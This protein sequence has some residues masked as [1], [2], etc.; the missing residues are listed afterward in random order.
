MCGIAG[1]FLINPKKNSPEQKLAIFT[2]FTKLF[3]ETQSRG[4]DASGF[5]YIDE[6]RHNELITVKG[7]ITSKN[8]VKEKKF[9][10]LKNELPQAL[11]AHCR[12]A[13]QGSPVENFNNHPITVDKK[14]AL[15]HNG[16]I[17]N[18]ASL[19]IDYDLKSKSKGQVDSEIIP[20]LIQLRI[21]QLMQ[22][23]ADA[24]NSQEDLD[25]IS[26]AKAINMTSQEL[27]GGFACAMINKD[28]PNTL[29][30]FNHNNPINLA[31]CE[32]LQCI[33]FASEKDHLE[34][35]FGEFKEEVTK[36]KIWKQNRYK[37]IPL[38]EK[39][40]DDTIIVIKLKD[41]KSKSKEV[42][43]VIP[44][45]TAENLTSEVDGVT[46]II[47]PEVEKDEELKITCYEMDTRSYTIDKTERTIW[48]QKD[49]KDIPNPK[50][51]P[52]WAFEKLTKTL[53]LKDGFKKVYTASAATSTT[54]HSSLVNGRNGRGEITTYGPNGSVEHQY[55]RGCG[56]GYDC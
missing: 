40:S 50:W 4:T 8:M 7:P 9:L 11:I 33:F 5:S 22:K 45:G 14:I 35:A 26:V 27:T 30:L 25:T 19:K 54:Q 49:Y 17:G 53:R 43:Q 20:L 13:T 46:T 39:V 21:K 42:V 12:A 47:Q 52:D 3:E 28:T 38:I 1:F 18:D 55:G 51:T 56:D 32:E 41:N 34:T 10:R 31:Y 16:M 37:Y 2:I 15:I 44:E 48:S 6:G 23:K 24:G 29:Y 36:Y